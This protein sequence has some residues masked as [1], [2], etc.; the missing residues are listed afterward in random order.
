MKVK[1]GGGHIWS[2]MMVFSAVNVF[3]QIG[4]QRCFCHY[5][6][7]HLPRVQLRAVRQIDRK[8][9]G[10]P[11]IYILTRHTDSCLNYHT[12]KYTER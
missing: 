11:F 7:M 12:D 9:Q 10:V 8:M 4:N 1:E 5:T 3:L 6:E 2:V